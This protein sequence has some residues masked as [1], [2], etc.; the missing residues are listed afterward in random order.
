[1]LSHIVVNAGIRHVDCGAIIAKESDEE[2]G[3]GPIRRS[4]GKSQEPST[5]VHD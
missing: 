2:D 1:M 3:R 5:V 4:S